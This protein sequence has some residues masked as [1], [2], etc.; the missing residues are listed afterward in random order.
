MTASQLL[1]LD[2]DTQRDFFLP[3]GARPVSGAQGIAPNIQKLMHYA[4]V[5]GIP[6]VSTLEARAK[7][8]PEFAQVRPYCV[9]GTRGQ[10]KIDGTTLGNALVVPND[11]ERAPDPEAVAAARQIMVEKQSES[12]FDNPHTEGLLRVF[13]PRLVI[14]FGVATERGVR[15]DVL[16]LCGRGY[17][18]SVV[19]DGVAG[20]SAGAAQEALREMR[21]ASAA[22]ITAPEILTQADPNQLTW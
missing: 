2:V 14:V 17:R 7:D 20:F 4:F 19:S 5:H 1:F 18:T 16:G 21:R 10:L 13:A 3:E 11:P 9:K 12:V 15:Q 22:F 6:V 8:D